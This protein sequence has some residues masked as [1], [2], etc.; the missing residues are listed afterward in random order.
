MDV[1][2]AGRDIARALLA[3]L[4]QTCAIAFSKYSK[5]Q[6]P[7]TAPRAR[8]VPPGARPSDVYQTLT[9]PF[10][11]SLAV[12]ERGTV[13]EGR[14]FGLE[15]GSGG[16]VPVRCHELQERGQGQGQGAPDPGTVVAAG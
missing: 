4:L 16:L 11:Y 14:Y 5:S 3:G 8:P 10:V 15:C 12:G 1:S 9:E 2:T 7:L 13:E 6:L